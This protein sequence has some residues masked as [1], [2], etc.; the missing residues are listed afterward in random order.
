MYQDQ[1]QNSSHNLSFSLIIIV[2]TLIDMLLISIVGIETG[3]TYCLCCSKILKSLYQY[4]FEA[5]IIFAKTPSP[6]GQ[7][8]MSFVTEYGGTLARVRHWMQHPVKLF[9]TPPLPY[10][11]PAHSLPSQPIPITIPAIFC[12][13]V[14]VWFF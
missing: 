6:V 10:R 1:V 9:Q 5:F 3:L 14:G 8:N 2:T 4:R 7:G 13:I 12:S 11:P